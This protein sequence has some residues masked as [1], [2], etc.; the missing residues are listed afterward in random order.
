MDMNY[1]GDSVRGS[2]SKRRFLARLY[3]PGDDVIRPAGVT[4][5]APDEG[6]TRADVGAGGSAQ[7]M[8]AR[9]AV[10]CDGGDEEFRPTG[11]RHAFLALALCTTLLGACAARQEDRGDHRREHSCRAQ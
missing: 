3:A 5:V 4:N 11:V 7:A 2:R 9:R 1:G 10:G 8:A 6:G